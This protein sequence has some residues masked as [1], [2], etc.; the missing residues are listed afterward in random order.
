MLIVPQSMPSPNYSS[1][2]ILSST[3]F[4]EGLARITNGGEG[5]LYGIQA[6]LSGFEPSIFELLSFAR[7][8]CFIK[9][10]FF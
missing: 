2:S 3:V 8:R 4:T 9:V 1:D 6:F 7:R 10:E 5:W